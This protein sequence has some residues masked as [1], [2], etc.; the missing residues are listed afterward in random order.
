MMCTRAGLSDPH[1][2]SLRRLTITPIWR[3]CNIY[4]GTGL[5]YH[6]LESSSRVLTAHCQLDCL[7]LE[8]PSLTEHHFGPDNP[9]SLEH[10]MRISWPRRLFLF[11][12]LNLTKN[13]VLCLGSERMRRFSL[14]ARNRKV[15]RDRNIRL[16]YTIAYFL[17]LH[18]V[19]ATIQH[20]TWDPA[21]RDVVFKKGY[22]IDS[23]QH[24]DQW[25]W[26]FFNE[27]ESVWSDQ[28]DEEQFV[29]VKIM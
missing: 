19:C 25:R 13:I 29:Q 20:P 28:S 6:L 16:T 2:A 11:R 10:R 27:D 5:L 7:T 4:Q 26:N 24:P 18:Q 8:L 22:V 17:E 9:D 14:D 1:C 12:H 23:D 15:H 3:L 21:L